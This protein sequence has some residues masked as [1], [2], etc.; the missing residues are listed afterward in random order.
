MKEENFF[1]RLLLLPLF[2]GMSRADFLEVAE[3]VKLNFQQRSKGNVLVEQDDLCTGLYFVLKGEVE[4]RKVSDQKDSELVEWVNM[5]MVLQPEAMFGL[6]TR[7]TRTFI[8]NTPLQLLRV[9][10]DVVRDI[11][12]DYSTFRI[13][14]LNLVSYRVQ[15]ANRL[16]WRNLPPVL[17]SRFIH[18]LNAHC[19]RPAG[20]KELKIGMVAL[21]ERLLATRLNVSKMLNNLE[22]KQLIEL[23]RGRIM[24]PCMEKLLMQSHIH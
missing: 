9:E 20:R 19:L 11:L 3:R 13:N 24:I 10:K 12:F 4:V 23:Y 8:A 7:Y 15:H 21:S 6:S 16:L 5:P 2:Q 18:Y 17:E 1:D 14:Y 22:E